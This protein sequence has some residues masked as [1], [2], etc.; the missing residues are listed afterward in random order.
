MAGAIASAFGGNKAEIL[1]QIESGDFGLSQLASATHSAPASGSAPATGAAP[2]NH[3][4]LSRLVK[5]DRQQLVGK[6][7]KSP[8][9]T[10]VIGGQAIMFL[11]FALSGGAAAYFDE[12]NAGLFQRLLSAPVTRGQ[13]LWSRFI[14]GTLLGLVQLTVLFFAGQLLYGIDV[15]GHLGNLVIVC[16]GAAAACTSF[17]MLIAAITPNAQAASGVATLLV[18]IM[19]ATGGAW[20]PTTFL[21]DFMEKIGKLTIVYWSMDG[22]ARVLWAGNSF[23]QLLP[24]LGI[25]FGIALGVMLIAVW[26]LNQKKIFG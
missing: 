15:L 2:A 10:R 4:M 19:A 21:P 23:V 5:I 16:I 17:G 20:F 7:V 3:D 9:A 6:D 1:E 24:T 8:D 13:L 18:M 11:L 14:W 26:R 22:F 12:K 25:L